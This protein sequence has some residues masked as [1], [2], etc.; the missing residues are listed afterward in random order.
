LKYTYD[1][2]QK[3]YLVPRKGR[4]P[5]SLKFE[6]QPEDEE[7]DAPGWIINP[8]FIV[9]DWDAPG[10][11]LKVDGKTMVPGA[12]FRIGYE[13]TPTGMDLVIWFKMK[14]SK[15]TTFSINPD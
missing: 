3:A 9:K 12:D 13:Q 8:A 5:T 10:V 6:L 14:A 1:P 11:I 15:N 2:A 4:G 7:I